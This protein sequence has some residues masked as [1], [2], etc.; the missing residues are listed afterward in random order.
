MSG[1]GRVKAVRVVLPLSQS[2]EVP[3]TVGTRHRSAI[4]ISEVSDAI[5]LVV[6]EERGTA[7]LA[8]KGKLVSAKSPEELRNLVKT[9][10]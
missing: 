4:G 3:K 8:Y 1:A 9:I 5:T 6:S 10:L 2:P 7:S